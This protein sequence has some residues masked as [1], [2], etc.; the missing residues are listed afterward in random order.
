M[1][2]HESPEQL[3]DWE[4]Q[5][6]AFLAERLMLELKPERPLR[7]VTDGANF[8]GYIV[9][10]H[11]RL[12]RRRVIGNLRQRLAAFER[13]MGWGEPSRPQVWVSKGRGLSAGGTSL[14]LAH[15]RHFCRQFY[16]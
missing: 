11:Y 14:R 12:G 9:R 2:V 1:L 3:R 7:P 6:E 10:P 16:F 13:R 8:L 4:H 5:I 15:L